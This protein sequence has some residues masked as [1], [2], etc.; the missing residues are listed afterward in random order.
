MARPCRSRP[1]SGVL[2]ERTENPGVLGKGRR[3]VYS[4]PRFSSYCSI[5]GCDCADLPVCVG[6]CEPSCRPRSA[7][8]DPRRPGTA[9]WGRH[10]GGG[11]QG[12]SR[13]V[14]WVTARPAARAPLPPPGPLRPHSGRYCGAH[15]LRMSLALRGHLDHTAAC[16]ASTCIRLPP[17]G[18]PRSGP[19]AP[20]PRNKICRSTF[21]A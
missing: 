4:P 15:A 11:F 16:A 12:G 6:F 19:A 1:V 2:E 14:S 8:Q 17:L 9:L 20:H 13:P 3:S 18:K 10:P 7:R 5:Q 21:V